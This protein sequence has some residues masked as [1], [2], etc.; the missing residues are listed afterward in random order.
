MCGASRALCLC[1]VMPRINIRTRVSL[2]IH[3]A[4]LTRSSNTG[5]L[6]RRALVNSDIRIRGEHKAPLDSGMLLLP[7]HRIF[8]LYPSGD[9]CEL[10]RDLVQ[11]APVPIQLIGP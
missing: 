4:E 7:N 6:A 9:A 8:L 1:D 10:T 2:L 5:L 3:C 11:E